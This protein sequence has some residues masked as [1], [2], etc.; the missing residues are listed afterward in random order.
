MF[1]LILD[2]VT[3]TTIHVKTGK[4]VT[5]TEKIEWINQLFMRDTL[6]HGHI[7]DSDDHASWHED[8]DEYEWDS[9]FEMYDQYWPILNS[10]WHT[11]I[12]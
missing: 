2:L 4:K 12:E 11:T 10:G 1:I 6:K 3:M 9:Y 5:L 7:E 8:W